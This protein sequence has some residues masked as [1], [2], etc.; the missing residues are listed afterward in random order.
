MNEGQFKVT[1]RTTC[2]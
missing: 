1:S 2:D